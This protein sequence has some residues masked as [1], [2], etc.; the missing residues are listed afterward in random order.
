MSLT[1]T[2]APPPPPSPGFTLSLNPTGLSVP[3]GG[4]GTTTLT[5]TPQGDFTGAV[6]LSLVGAPQGVT[7]S[8]TGLQVTGSGPVTQALTI[9]VAGT[10]QPGN[11]PLKVR[12]TGG[13]ISR[14]ADL[15]LT[16][17]QAPALVLVTLRDTYSTLQGAYY[18]VGFGAWTALS[19]QS[20]QASFPAQ[21]NVD[22]EVALRCGDSLQF[23][24]ASTAQT[25]TASFV[26]SSGPGPQS[27][28]VNFTVQVPSQIGGRP[29]ADGDL[30]VVSSL[31]I[32]AQPISNGQA[33]LQVQ[34]PPGN[35]K[36]LVSVFRVDTS[37]GSPQL[38]PIGGKLVDVNVPQSG[39]SLT[40]NN[41][42]YAAF[43]VRNISATLPS[44][45]SGNVFVLFFKDGMK[46][47]GVAGGF[48]KYGVLPGAGGVYL[49]N[50]FAQKD[51]YSETLG[52]LKDTGGAD[53]NVDIPS[54][55]PQNGFSAS[56][57]TFTLAY[58]NAQ[59]YGLE[60][61]G[62]ARDAQTGDPLRVRAFL[63]PSGS[64]TTFTLPD[65]RAQLGYSLAPSGSNVGYNAFATV[66]GAGSPAEILFEVSNPE[67][68]E[69]LLRNL[70]FAFAT[71]RGSY[72]LP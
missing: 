7:L 41:Q 47:F 55:W 28:T 45:F 19:F 31:N 60:L 57:T 15:S 62:L 67:L 29:V 48:G 23:F 52:V 5:L 4:S 72:T 36:V 9:S 40:V 37:G 49:G 39:G 21:G 59:A 20:G 63:Y 2:A 24:K 35:Q 38:E 51:D 46:S 68:T 8:P 32:S 16:V 44:G 26:C 3:Q 50:F 54:P 22:Y 10:V 18:R 69:S 12:A 34:L 11:Y 6:S 70:D 43:A 33:T 1:V 14:E 61:T 42:G 58:P 27:V 71:K 65:L 66:R 25:R 17:D 64:A 13:N 30:V 53:W 56:G